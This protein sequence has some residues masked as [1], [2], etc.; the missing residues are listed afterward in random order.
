MTKLEDLAKRA[1]IAVKWQHASGEAKTVSQ[2][3]QRAILE[4]LGHPAGSNAAIRESYQRLAPSSSPDALTVLRPGARFNSSAKAIAFRAEDGS[5]TE[6][7]PDSGLVTVPKTPGYYTVEPSGEKVAVVPRSAFGLGRAR[8]W[9]VATQL[10]A[11]RGGGAA[12]FGDFGALAEFSRKAGSQGASAVAISPV[13]ALFGGAPDHISP[14]APS[15]RLYLN[16]LY[17]PAPEGMPDTPGALIDWQAAAKAKTEVLFRAFQNISDSPELDAFIQDG[18]TRLLDHARFEVLDARYRRAGVMGWRQWP[19]KHRDSSSDAVKALTSDDK[20]VRF[21]LFLQ[22]QAAKGLQAAQAAAVGAGM[23]VGLITDMAVGMDPSGSHAWSVSG[24]VL[25]GLSIGA[26]PDIYNPAGQNWGLTGFS[27]RGLRSG[28]Y[29]GF[30]GTL[31]AAM[32]HAG[33]IRLDHAMG[34]Q[35]LWVVPDGASASDGAYLHYPFAELLGLLTL[36]SQRNQAIVVAEDLGTVPTGFRERISRAGLLGMRVLWFERGSKGAFLPPK[37]WDGQ[38]A[39]LSTTHD[40][41]TLAG[42]WTSHDIA[43]REKLGASPATLKAERKTRGQERKQLWETLQKSGCAAGGAPRPSNPGKFA[44]AAFASL[45]KTPCPIV[46]IPVE[47]FIGET[48]QPNIPGTIDEHPNW[49]R[50]LTSKTPL[51]STEA[52]R[53]IATLK[54]ERP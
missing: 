31:R 51:S 50:R 21:Q 13:H 26:P 40:L 7:V 42:W 46:L 5:V 28:G 43:W 44:D 45:A 35:R 10:Y 29:A 52:Q 19:E 14:Y 20:D 18:G 34:L 22:W 9:A 8:L 3:V 47:D 36:E 39:A 23:K 27:P 1:G 53:R 17:A 38:A 11:L 54:A 41:P 30:I 33:G 32:R 2:D 12:G 16:P 15:S 48:E 37:R 24:E 25:Q 6:A 4:K 49:R